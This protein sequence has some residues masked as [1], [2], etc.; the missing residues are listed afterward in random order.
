M[1]AISTVRTLFAYRRS[2]FH[3]MLIKH[4]YLELSQKCHKSFPFYSVDI[5][6]FKSCLLF[7][8]SERENLII[9]KFIVNCIR[10]QCVTFFEQISINAIK[11]HLTQ[12]CYCT[13][14]HIVESSWII[15]FLFIKISG[16]KLIECYLLHVSRCSIFLPNKL[17]NAIRKYRKKNVK[18]TDIWPCNAD[19]HLKSNFTFQINHFHS[20]NQVVIARI[21][22]CFRPFF[23]FF[24]FFFCWP[25]AL[26]ALT[27]QVSF[28]HYYHY[29]Y[30]YCS[31]CLRFRISTYIQCN[32]AQCTVYTSSNVNNNTMKTNRNFHIT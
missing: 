20:F 19:L 26:I 17:I 12:Y 9:S 23:L 15:F 1:I 27:R 7:S 21:I 29:Y 28:W 32:S 14:L 6:Q 25:S 2:V 10:L 11:P 13:Q 31:Y 3:F 16:Y 4:Y 24:A 18:N 8:R 30:Y 22:Q 5:F